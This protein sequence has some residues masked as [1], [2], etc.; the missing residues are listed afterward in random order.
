MGRLRA[1]I[2]LS[3]SQ[4]PLGMK[5]PSPQKKGGPAGPPQDP[6][7]PACLEAGRDVIVATISKLEAGLVTEA[8][9]WGAGVVLPV[10][11]H[12]KLFTAVVRRD[13]RADSVIRRGS[14]L[15]DGNANL[16][17]IAR[18]IGAGADGVANHLGVVGGS[19]EELGVFTDVL[20][21]LLEA[22]L[23][24]RAF[25]VVD[26]S[27]EAEDLA[28]S[29]K[30]EFVVGALGVI[31]TSD[32]D[33]LIVKFVPARGDVAVFAA[34]A[35]DVGFALKHFDCDLAAAEEASHQ[36]KQGQD[37]D[38]LHVGPSDSF[39]TWPM[40]LAPLSLC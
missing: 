33:A 36:G 21:C 18:Q 29:L 23:A 16:A 14:L 22:E 32:G 13:V 25:G 12:P 39:G 11:A 15:L 26:T 40:V 34:K 1:S 35:I 19:Q 5:S 38:S 17:G 2:F 37:D 4:N 10:A 6:I 30:A 24:V 7:T 3:G 31:E 8:V 28:G 27:A 20:A 9:R